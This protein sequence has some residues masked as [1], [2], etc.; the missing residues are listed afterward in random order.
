MR[1]ISDPSYAF[2]GY[3]LQL[4]A[5]DVSGVNECEWEPC[6]FNGTCTDEE[7]G[8]SCECGDDRFARNC[9]TPAATCTPDDIYLEDGSSYNLT[10]F[11]YNF[12]GDVYGLRHGCRVT[13]TVPR[14]HQV[15]VDFMDVNLSQPWEILSFDKQVYDNFDEYISDDN[16]LEI[17]YYTQ[18]PWASWSLVLYDYIPEDGDECASEPCQNG[19]V[20][21]DKQNGFSC[22]CRR[23]FQ[24]P[25]CQRQTGLS[26][27]GR[28]SFLCNNARCVKAS[29]VC[30]GRNHCGDGSDEL[31]CDC[32]YPC[33]NGRCI[34]ERYV[35]DDKNQC[36]DW[37]DELNCQ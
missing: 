36:G 37:T 31:N 19:G 32:E 25:T 7:D 11:Y 6:A 30:D 3:L 5:I 10:S 2:R 33:Y 35:C 18:T 9:M 1:F 15:R 20:C 21:I 17:I 34:P 26:P 8:Y 28:N 29:K 22:K 24:G 13:V 16:S 23:G 4:S 12:I 14:G 27:C